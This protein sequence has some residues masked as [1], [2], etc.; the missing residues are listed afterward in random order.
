MK[1][2]L[3]QTGYDDAVVCDTG[4]KIIETSTGNLFWYKDNVWFT[5]DL[6]ESG[7]EGVMRNRILAV[8]KEQG[9]EYRVVKQ[10]ISALFDAQQIFVCNSL[11]LLVP[12]VGLFNPVNQQ[13]KDYIVDQ[14]KHIQHYVQN[15]INLNAI[16]V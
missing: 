4:Q 8:M 10:D 3:V 9:L 16:K 7:V 2:A 11:M 14:T 1:Q 12:V 13:C 5:A 15:R 6:T